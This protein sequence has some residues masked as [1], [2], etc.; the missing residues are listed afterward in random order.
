MTPRE[1]VDEHGSP[2]WLVDLD[3]VRRRVR[4]F[5]AVWESRFPEVD[6]AYSYKTN[7]LP[8]ILIAVADQGAAPEVV[9]YG[10]Y[11]LAREV[12]G[13][14]G[15]S[16]VVNGPAKPDRLLQR[17]GEDGALVVVDGADELRRAAAAGV[18]RVGLRVRVPGVGDEPSRFGIPADEIADA[19]GAARRLGLDVE[20]LGAHVAS[21]GLRSGVAADRSLAEA[22]TVAWPPRGPDRHVRAATLL[23]ELARVVGVDTIDLGGGHPAPAALAEHADAVCEAL[24]RGGFHGRLL[25]EPGRAIVADAVDLATTVVA[26]KRLADGARCA[27]A[28]AGTNLLPGAL[29]SWPRIEAAEDAGTSPKTTLVTGPLCLNVDVLH[30]AAVLPALHPGSLLLVRSVGAYHQSQSTQFGDLRPAAV[31]RDGGRWHLV[32]SGE[33]IS[34]LIA[35]DLAGSAGAFIE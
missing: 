13:A 8:A 29:W 23:A 14:D 25:L 20:A 24:R 28:D 15:E 4:E 11:V 35:G 30:P 16:I 33:S 10:E 26:V 18:R 9:S 17:A 5:R 1:L 22:M 31:G 19:A 21:T 7:R 12:T 32:A 6:V 27:I 2:L 3:R 34:S